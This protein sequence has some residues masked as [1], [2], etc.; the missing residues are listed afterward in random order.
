M[1]LVLRWALVLVMVLAAA[2]AT[3][4]KIGFIDVEKAVS[5]VKQGRAQIK[6]LEDWATPRRER[7]EQL[8]ARAVEVA[9]QLTAQRSVATPDV[10]ADLEQRALEA[11][12]AFEDAGRAFNRELDAK[13]NEMLGDVALKMG[14]VASDYAKANDFDAIFTVQAQPLV[15]ISEAADLTDTL[16]R[17][18]DERFPAN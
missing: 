3:A 14:Q 5:T 11:R 9:N 1:R 13:Q 6:A 18:Y 2:P 7:L 4:G 12:K 8:Q 17:L 10:I 16:I 15:Y